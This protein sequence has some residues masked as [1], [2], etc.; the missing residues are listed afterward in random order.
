M[1]AYFSACAI[2]GNLQLAWLSNERRGKRTKNDL[3][4]SFLMY[5]LLQNFASYLLKKGWWGGL[6]RKCSKVLFQ[7]KLTTVC[8][9]RFELIYTLLQ[10][11][12]LRRFMSDRYFVAGVKIAYLRPQVFKGYFLDLDLFSIIGK[13]VEDTIL[14]ICSQLFRS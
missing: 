5:G 1:R 12:Q 13:R 14:A 6:L 3:Y 9:P 7:S 11:I 8:L 4:F 10:K 2:I